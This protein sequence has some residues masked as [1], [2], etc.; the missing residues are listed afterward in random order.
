MLLLLAGLDAAYMAVDGAI[1]RKH[2]GQ[3]CFY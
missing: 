3:Y 1:R 2:R